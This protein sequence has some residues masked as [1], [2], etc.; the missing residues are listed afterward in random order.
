MHETESGELVLTRRE[1]QKLAAG[2][3]I[4]MQ[5]DDGGW[6]DSLF[7]TNSDD[8]SSQR[9]VSLTVR[10][11][12]EVVAEE[13]SEINAAGNLTA[14]LVETESD[15]GPI[16]ELSATGDAGIF[17][18]TDGDGVPELQE[19]AVDLDGGDIQNA[20][21]IG[22]DV[23]NNVRYASDGAQDAID[24]A[25]EL[26]NI[27]GG[28]L[29]LEAGVYDFDAVGSSVITAN[30][31]MIIEGQGDDTVL[32]RDGDVTFSGD[33]TPAFIHVTGNHV[34]VRDLRIDSWPQTGTPT[35]DA[36]ANIILDDCEH[37]VVRDISCIGGGVGVRLLTT[38]ECSVTD[39]VFDGPMGYGIA[40][41]HNPDDSK[42]CELNSVESNTVRADDGHFI[43]GVFLSA[44]SRNRVANNDLISYWSGSSYG[45]DNQAFMIAS[46]PDGASTRADRTLISGNRLIAKGDAIINAFEFTN[47][48]DNGHGYKNVKI[49]NNY[50]EGFNW[51][52]QSTDN[53]DDASAI[54]ISENTFDRE[55]GGQTAIYFAGGGTPNVSVIARGNT[56]VGFDRGILVASPAWYEG[57]GNTYIDCAS[58]G[59]D[60]GDTTDEVD[61]RGASV[62]G[63]P[64]TPISIRS[65]TSDAYVDADVP[66]NDISDSSTRGIINGVGINSGDP[67]STGDWSGNEQ[68]A[69]DY[70]VV[71]ED[72][73][74]NNLYMAVGGSFAQIG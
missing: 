15:I 21:S 1:Y 25:N 61:I 40:L 70:G 46:G 13:V 29:V 37:S 63:S 53:P 49:H 20:G 51:G 62:R 12:G 2:G 58:T 9:E 14:E 52:I 23:L 48:E 5:S 28:K 3:S 30:A 35:M 36:G 18:D 55:G 16:I 74:N 31:P 43:R 47:R 59:I 44:A 4:V 54:T 41:S 6:L 50:I 56:I 11:D 19:D 60:V 57:R 65:G 39:S 24:K 7:G 42:L 10:D 69:E 26:N 71:I 67:N 32:T 34:T 38:Y 45:F 73:S 22:T 27:G 66:R 33:L 68:R 64:A 17:D 8:G 72:T